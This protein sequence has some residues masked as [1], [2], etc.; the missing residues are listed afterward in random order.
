MDERFHRQLKLEEDYQSRGFQK[1]AAQDRRNKETNYGSHTS[2]GFV[3]RRELTGALVKALGALYK[4]YVSLKKEAPCSTALVL[5]FEKHKPHWGRIGHIGLVTL[6]DNVF[7][8]N[9]TQSTVH[10]IIGK[11]IEDDYR[12]RYFKKHDPDLYGTIEKFYLRSTSG[13]K[14]KVKSS[15]IIFQK[16]HADDE[17]GWEPWSDSICR[18]IGSWVVA[19]AEQAF[20]HITGLPLLQD[21]N[22]ATKRGKVA[23]AY[24]L[25]E[26]LRDVEV[27]Q[28]IISAQAANYQDNPMVCPPV[29]WSEGIYGGLVTNCISKR[30]P[31]IRGNGTTTPSELA[32]DALN[33]LQNVAWKINPF[34]L[35]QLEYFYQRGEGINSTDPFQPYLAPEPHDIPKLNP[36]LAELPPLHQ[37]QSP[38]AHLAASYEARNKELRQLTE[39]HNKQ[40]ARRRNGK[41]HLL[42]HAAAQRFKN[43][44]RFWF[45]WSF[46]FRTRMYPIS[47]LN[48]QQGNH[49][50]ALLMFADGYT[51]RDADGVITDEHTEYWLSVHL[52]TTK[53]FSKETF[54]GRVSWVQT[55]LREVSLVA[56]DPLGRGRVYWTEEADEPWTYLAACR[57]YYECFIAKTKNE[58]HLQC[59]IDATASGLQILGAL[60]GDESTCKLVNVI[61]TGKPSDLYQ[62]IIDKTVKLIKDDRPRRRGIPLD[63]LSRSVAKAPTMTLAY[64]STPWRRE[65]Q[66]LEAINGK[67]GLALNLK[68][69]KVKYIAGKLDDAIAFVIPGATNLLSWLS[70]TAVMAM[71]RGRDSGKTFIT[72]VTPSG[73]KVDQLYFKS[74]LRRVKTVALGMTRYRKETVHEKTDKIDLSKIES[75][76]AANFVH[77]LDA[78]V[79]HFACVATDFPMSATH[80]CVYA[81]AGKDMDTIAAEVR[82]AFIKVVE[83]D[84]IQ[85]FADSNNVPEEVASIDKKRNHSFKVN[86]VRRSRYFFC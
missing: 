39:W 29:P 75:S 44:E 55:N 48:P 81:R 73:C 64:G 86:R 11:K 25:H 40:A 2:A 14:Q 1:K 7:Y 10:L 9:H 27:N 74:E 69:E 66:V 41:I 72:W 60:M 84:P 21:R 32:Y 22:I 56:T 52:A 31:V 36:A 46:D 57:E 12:F 8:S 65:R 68:W 15:G 26:C 83:A 4:D 43:E 23:K 16:A 35:E 78:S 54:E 18:K 37:G 80:D 70:T 6:L 71:N 38:P 24:G 67:R 51:F 76:T 42:V 20:T 63:Q 82:D 77:S 62:A 19:V 61:S 34:V 28:Q 45:P 79:I 49:V 3:I 47:I 33:R 58:T 59:G 53:G 85:S 50:N 30:Y 17:L 13:Y 5:H